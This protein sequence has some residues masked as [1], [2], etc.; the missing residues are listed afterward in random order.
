[1]KTNTKFKD[2]HSKEKNWVFRFGS[3]SK[4]S[5]D[6]QARLCVSASNSSQ[7]LLIITSLQHLRLIKARWSK[8]GTFS[9]ENQ[10]FWDEAPIQN[11]S[12]L[13]MA[14]GLRQATF[15]PPTP[16]NRRQPA[17]TNANGCT[18]AVTV[19]VM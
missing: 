5:L 18:A 1:M 3:G 2:A 9:S 10:L 19:C 6:S 16:S 17:G 11:L 14:P 13:L 12:G 4:G 8:S 15:T 7:K